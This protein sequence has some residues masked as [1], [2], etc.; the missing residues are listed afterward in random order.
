MLRLFSTWVTLLKSKVSLVTQYRLTK[1]R[2]SSSLIFLRPTTT[3]ASLSNSKA[4][5]KKAGYEA[6]FSVK[7]SDFG[8]SWG[9]ENGALGDEVDLVVGLEGDWSA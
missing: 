6:I 2:S 5:L 1:Q 9:V 8:M 7:R 3:W 4:N